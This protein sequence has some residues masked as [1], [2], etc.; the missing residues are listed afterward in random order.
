MNISEVQLQTADG[1]AVE[2]STYVSGPTIV[3]LVRYYG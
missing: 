2:L 1:T 3:V